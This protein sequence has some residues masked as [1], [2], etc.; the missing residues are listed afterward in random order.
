MKIWNSKKNLKMPKIRVGKDL[1]TRKFN[2]FKVLKVF[3]KLAT[4]KFIIFFY[5]LNH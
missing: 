2:Y 1:G 5:L 4:G 3:V